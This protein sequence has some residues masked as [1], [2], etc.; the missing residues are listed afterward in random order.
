MTN[1]LLN[2]GPD[3]ERVDGIQDGL[4][5]LSNNMG[6]DIPDTVSDIIPYAGAIVASGRL[7]CGVSCSWR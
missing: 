1:R 7:I 2:I 3:L 4:N 5:T 6:I